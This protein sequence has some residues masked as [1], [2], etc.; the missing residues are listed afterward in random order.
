MTAL[1]QDA[2]YALRTLLQ[3]P[4]FTAVVVLPLA[5]GIG[6]TAIFSVIHSVLLRP[7]PFAEPDRL[8]LA[9]QS[10]PE[11]GRATMPVSPP[12]FADWR[13]RSQL[14]EGLAAFHGGSPTAS[15][16]RSPATTGKLLVLG[17]LAPGV[18]ETA[19]TLLTGLGSSFKDLD[20]ELHQ[21]ARRATASVGTEG[22]A[23]SAA[24]AEDADPET[25]AEVVE[26]LSELEERVWNIG[27][28]LV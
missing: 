26:R 12:N 20:W 23:P 18:S 4:G 3:Q 16:A 22:G 28:E 5:L 27:N 25:L 19:V 17:R 14:F 8:F 11:K 2:R 6:P 9:Y 13:E 15:T 21:A 7:L 1:I 10:L 24:E